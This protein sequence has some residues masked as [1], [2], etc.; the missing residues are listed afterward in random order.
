MVLV[1]NHGTNDGPQC[2][3]RAVVLAL[4]ECTAKYDRELYEAFNTCFAQLPVGA[5]KGAGDGLMAAHEIIGAAFT[6]QID[7]R[8]LGDDW[9]FIEKLAPAGD[10]EPKRVTDFRTDHLEPEQEPNLGSYFQS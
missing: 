4:Q 1:I 6:G 8:A 10:R 5:I 3:W 9:E 2:W 7:H